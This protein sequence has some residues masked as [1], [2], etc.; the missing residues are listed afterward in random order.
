MNAGANAQMIVTRPETM[1]GAERKSAV[2]R[3]TFHRQF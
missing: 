2:F 3:S 1:V